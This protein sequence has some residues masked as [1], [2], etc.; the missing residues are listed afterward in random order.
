MWFLNKLNSGPWAGL[1]LAL[2]MAILYYVWAQGYF[3]HGPIWE[4]FTSAFLTIK[5]VEANYFCSVIDFLLLK[6]R[7]ILT[8]F[9]TE[10]K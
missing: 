5:E 3:S 4:S 7:T 1:E 8:F 10:Q 9:K 2:S 6:I